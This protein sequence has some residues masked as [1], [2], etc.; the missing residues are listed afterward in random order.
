[1]ALQMRWSVS[2]QAELKQMDISNI[3]VHNLSPGM[4]TT[5]LLMSGADTA[6]S[7]FFINC[8]AETPDV[9]ANFLVPRIREV[10]GR[11]SLSGAASG[12]YLEFLTPVKAYSSIFARL[13]TGK[14]KSRWVV[15]E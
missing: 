8:L 15:E 7:K 12:T 3:G 14:N 9:V 6:Q 4:V 13:L 1:M 10:P 5:E 11:R 2:M